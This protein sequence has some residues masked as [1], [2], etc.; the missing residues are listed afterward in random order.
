VHLISTHTF[1]RPKAAALLRRRLTRAVPMS[2][3]A[4]GA[5]G[6]ATLFDR[7]LTLS[8]SE[9]DRMLAARISI[10]SKKEQQHNHAHH[11]PP[12]LSMLCLSMICTKT[13]LS[14]E[15]CS[16]ARERLAPSAALCGVAL[17][18]GER[19][20]ALAADRWFDR[21]SRLP[22]RARRK[23]RGFEAEEEDEALVVVLDWIKCRS[24][25]DCG[26]ATW[27]SPNAHAIDPSPVHFLTRL[28][29]TGPG[30]PRHVHLGE[31]LERAASC[32]I[33]LCVCIVRMIAIVACRLISHT[34]PPLA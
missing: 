28:D 10:S 12:L 20:R 31:S 15:T 8:R 29:S 33:P 27:G 6:Q 16:H 7:A 13:D 5:W 2:T 32:C 22:R 24:T 3:N 26:P 17:C 14:N 18:Q 30:R 4:V 11:C 25:I 34:D 9:R 19:G 23:G 1:P 21:S